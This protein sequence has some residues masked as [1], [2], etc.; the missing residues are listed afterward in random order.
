MKKLSFLLITFLLTINLYAERTGF[1]NL[2]KYVSID[3]PE[4]IVLIDSTKTSWH[5]ESTLLPVKAI[6]SIYKNNKTCEQIMTETGEKL[7]V[8]AEQTLFDWNGIQNSLSIISGS[9]QGQASYGFGLCT[10]LSKDKRILL[11]LVWCP[12]EYKAECFPYMA[13][14][15]DS[16][17]TDSGSYFECGAFTTFLYPKNDEDEPLILN[18]AGKTIETKLDTSDLEAA[19]N[20]I[21]NEYKVLC[22]YRN[23]SE[24]KKAWQRYYRLIFRDSCGRLKNLAQDVCA[25]L[26]DSCAD[27]TDYAHKLLT[28]TQGFEYSREKTPSDLECLPSVLINGGSDCDSRSLLLCTLLQLVNINSSMLVSAVHSH[29]LTILES[30]HPGFSFNINGIN[31]LPGETTAKDLTWGKISSEQANLEDWVIVLLP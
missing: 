6:I 12:E 1:G 9:I 3:L 25:A 4:D 10:K 14:F 18:I 8:E 16:L 30:D 7:N 31:F 20:F 27:E 22:L 5:L 21:E 24:W 15:M 29:A 17:Y 26:E 11:M 13:S 28:W 2:S 23:H 19:Q